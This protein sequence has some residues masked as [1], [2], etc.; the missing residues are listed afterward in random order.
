MLIFDSEDSASSARDALEDY[1]QNQIDEN[2]DYR[3]AEIPKLE[4]ARINQ[5]EE[6]ILFV[7]AND[8]EAAQTA[9]E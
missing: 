8:M 4:N 9:V 7:V 1:V 6:T 5:R 3:P 2:S